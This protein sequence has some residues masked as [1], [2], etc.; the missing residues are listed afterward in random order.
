M[1]LV[2]DVRL[3]QY[4][5]GAVEIDA[6]LR[7]LFWTCPCGCGAIGVVNM[8]EVSV[9]LEDNREHITVKAPLGLI[10]VDDMIHW[11]GT[12]IKG[13]WHGQLLVDK[14]GS[15]DITNVTGTTRIF[16]QDSKDVKADPLRDSGESVPPNGT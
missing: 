7:A 1:T 6:T 3:A 10:N 9:L 5:P 12:L 4:V 2:P 16:L 15:G 8:N 11:S 14:S 13:Q